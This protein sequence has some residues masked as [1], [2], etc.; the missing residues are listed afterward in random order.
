ME[1]D[2]KQFQ[3]VLARPLLCGVQTVLTFFGGG[4]VCCVCVCVCVGGGGVGGGGRVI[5]IVLSHPISTFQISR[6]HQGCII[7]FFS[8]LL[9]NLH[10][11]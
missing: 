1:P 5:K 10:V 4:G 6:F 2:C 3:M 8:C 9:L 7:I 11:K